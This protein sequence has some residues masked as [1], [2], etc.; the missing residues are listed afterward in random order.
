VQQQALA[1]SVESVSDVAAGSVGAAEEGADAIGVVA[2]YELP[3]LEDVPRLIRPIVVAGIKSQIPCS[4]R[5]DFCRSLTIRNN[6]NGAF[7]IKMPTMPI[8]CYLSQ[9]DSMHLQQQ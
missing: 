7:T 9:S 8:S 1:E 3:V 4:E 6:G 2:Y 5:P